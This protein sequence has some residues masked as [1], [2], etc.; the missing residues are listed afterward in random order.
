[1][2]EYPAFYLDWIFRKS[3]ATY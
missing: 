3:H 1:V 2:L